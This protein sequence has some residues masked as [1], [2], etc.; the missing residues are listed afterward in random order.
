MAESVVRRITWRNA[1][2]ARILLLGMLFMFL[3]HFFWMVYSAIFVALI[4][5]LLAIV[6]YAPANYL[7][8]WMPFRLSFTLVVL[9]F[10]AS[11]GM[12][13]LA[14]IPQILHQFGLLSQELPEAMNRAGEWLSERTGIQRDQEMVSQVNAQF[15]GFMQRFLPLAFGVISAGIG[16]FAI[17]VLAIFLGAQPEVYRNLIIRVTPPPNRA[18]IAR[19]Y[20]EAGRCLRNW[21]LGKAISMLAIGIFTWIGLLLFGIPGALALAAIAALL[22]FI[23]NLGPTIAA[24]PAIVAAFL[25]S[26]ST[27]LWVGVFYI[28]LQQVQSGISVP[29]VERRAVNIP[30]AA[31]LVWQLM[32]AIGFGILGLF[33]ATPLLAV[34]VVAVRI[35]YIEPTE[36]R[37]EWDRRDASPRAP[38]SPEPAGEL[39]SEGLH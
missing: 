14:I 36:E 13:M 16:S 6:L 17:L 1:D 11:V 23:P 28:V 5:V 37:Y 29:L 26:P 21:V 8:R 9:T 20:D 31:L 32:L 35:L 19:V 25:I 33:V 39:A 18:R 4:A 12:L 24:I 22:E 27:A 30:P 10:I 7:S 38:E 15:L 2:I 3:W 34:I